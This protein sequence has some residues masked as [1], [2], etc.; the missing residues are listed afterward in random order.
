[1]NLPR[2][3]R[4]VEC[5]GIRSSVFFSFF[6]GHSNIP[7]TAKNRNEFPSPEIETKSNLNPLAISDFPRLII[8]KKV[9]LGYFFCR[10][11]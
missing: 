4:G 6:F 9:N 2:M 3:L 10:F 11:F 5:L 1:M 7:K 8:Q